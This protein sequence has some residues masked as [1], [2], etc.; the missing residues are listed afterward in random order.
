MFKRTAT[1]GGCSGDEITDSCTRNLCME[2]DANE[3]LKNIPKPA[4]VNYSTLIQETVLPSS[5]VPI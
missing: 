5:V 1:L 2:R 3:W 4:V